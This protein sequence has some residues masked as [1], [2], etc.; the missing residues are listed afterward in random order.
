M[1]GISSSRR[2]EPD[3][4]GAVAWHCRALMEGGGGEQ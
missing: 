1:A 4:V 2:W 3:A